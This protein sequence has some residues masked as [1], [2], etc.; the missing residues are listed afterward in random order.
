MTTASTSTPPPVRRFYGF[1][2]YFGLISGAATPIGAEAAT[3]LVVNGGFETPRISG[4][5][6]YTAPSGFTGWTV[7]GGG[8]DLTAANFYSPATGIQSLDLNSVVSGRIYQDLLTV[9]GQR[10]LLTFSLAA[11]P[12]PDNPA[13][14]S[15]SVKRLEARWDAQVLGRYSHD[16]TGRTASN[17]GWHDITAL[18]TGT[19]SD[20]LTFLSITP[21]SAGP[22]IDNVFLIPV[23][24][25]TTVWLF[26]ASALATS[27]IFGPAHAGT[28]RRTPP[29]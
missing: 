15:P 21:G 16:A 13:F 22:A 17:V 18:V 23:P 29:H 28:R 19:G 27:M 5:F 25:P 9:P 26:V 8:V 10:Y 2:G 20:R 7:A 1:I 11:N 6:T 14:P 24:E 3:N 12:L 4:F